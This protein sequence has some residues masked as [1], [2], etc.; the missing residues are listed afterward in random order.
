MIDVN[1]S[2]NGQ[3]YQFVSLKRIS[4]ALSFIA[5]KLIIY[6]LNGLGQQRFDSW[7]PSE[8][9]LRPVSKKKFTKVELYKNFF[10]IL[11]KKADKES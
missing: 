10:R 4:I 1:N 8:F 11:T 2:G 9:I 3:F 5:G 6:S 7:S